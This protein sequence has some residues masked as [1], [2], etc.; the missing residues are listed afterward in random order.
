MDVPTYL[1][2]YLAEI[3]DIKRRLKSLSTGDFDILE[4]KQLISI[5]G[6]RTEYFLRAAIVPS[7]GFKD[8]F[9]GVINALKSHGISKGLRQDLHQLRELYN[10]VKHNPESRPSITDALQRLSEAES[11]G[12]ALRGTSIGKVHFPMSRRFHRI[13]W[14]A[15]WDHYIGGDTEVHILFPSDDSLTPSIDCIHIAISAWDDVKQDLST[16]G[17]ISAGPEAIPHHVYETFQSEADFHDAFSFEG[18]YRDILSTLAKHE[19]RVEGLIEPLHRENTMQSM[20]QAFA[21]GALDVA[22]AVTDPDELSAAIYVQVI[23]VY[24]VAPEWTRLHQWCKEFGDFVGAIS[25]EQR[26]QLSGPVWLGGEAF[27]LE[28]SRALAKHKWLP[29]LISSKL[30]MCLST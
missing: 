4:V 1:E 12:S 3:A 13:L 14:V 7:T 2:Q 21:L 19:F 17:T 6:L 25:Q 24:A 30:V 28:S 9:A 16:L 22:D 10:D 20:M 18:E 26:P 23:N 15:G 27:R 29:L 8:D 5:L 11:F